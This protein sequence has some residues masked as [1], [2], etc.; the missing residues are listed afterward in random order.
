MGLDGSRRWPWPIY[1]LC[2]G[3]A[4]VLVPSVE[5]SRGTLTKSDISTI[6]AVLKTNYP[7]PIVKSDTTI[8]RQYGFIEIEE[9]AEVRVCGVNN[10]EENEFVATSACR[11]RALYDPEDEEWVNF[12]VPG[13]GARKSKLGSGNVRFIP[14]CGNSY[15]RFKRLSGSLTIK[16][17]T[18]QSPKVLTDLL[19]LVTSGLR[20]LTLCGDA[21]DP[22]TTAIHVDLCALATACPELQYLYVS[23]MNVVI[24]SH[25]D[26]LCRWSIKTLCLHEH[27]GSLSDLTRCLRTSTL[28]MARQL[29][30]LEVTARRHGYD[31]AEVNEL[32]THDGEFLPVTMV[33]FPTTSKAA[34]ISVV[35][36]ASS[37]ATKPI[38]RLDAYML[39]LI[40]VFASTPEQRSVVYW[41]RQFK[42]R[43][44]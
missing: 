18:F 37:S 24:S 28:R 23:E 29:V 16:Y 8:L 36:S 41:C 31:E 26:A 27:S 7:Q 33:K 44:E 11:C 32:K 2:C 21:E 30:I 5:I 34:M 17:V 14:D 38:H 13:H 15:F 43:A 6:H 25:D 9:G 12:I 20:S 19:A 3:P 10:D 35:L 1:A 39:S 22:A 4:D 42:P 40:F